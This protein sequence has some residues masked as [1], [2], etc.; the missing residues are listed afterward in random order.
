MSK[1][2]NV[3]AATFAQFLLKNMGGSETFKVNLV[4]INNIDFDLTA[5]EH[6]LGQVCLCKLQCGNGY[7]VRNIL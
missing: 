5:S 1:E 7:G 2:R 3:I 6:D 4:G